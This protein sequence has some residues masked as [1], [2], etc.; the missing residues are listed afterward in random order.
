M[1]R[2]RERMQSPFQPP[3]YI[4]AQILFDSFNNAGGQPN[5]EEMVLPKGEMGFLPS[6]EERT[7]QHD[8]AREA[9]RAG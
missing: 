9:A 2:Q 6:L 7:L 3:R 5:W 8:F 1:F 4:A